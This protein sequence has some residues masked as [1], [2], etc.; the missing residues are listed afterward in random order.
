MKINNELIKLFDKYEKK[1]YNRGD[2]IF[3]TNEECNKIGIILKGHIIITSITYQEKEETISSLYENEVFG[4]FLIFSSHPFYLGDIIADKKSTIV[5]ITKNELLY[6]MK[7]NNIFMNEFLKEMSDNAI[8]IKQQNKLL[9]HKN[10]KDR[11][12]YYFNTL[13]AKQNSK[14]II[15]PSITKLALK[16]SLPR[17]SVSR[18]LTNLVNE[19]LIMKVKNIIT[20]QY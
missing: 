4:N 14:T 13:S 18:E 16:L 6:L 1:E 5:F 11:I 15:V 19:G 7:N 12:L 10:I 2:I 17:P 20:L 8:D 9:A 3:S